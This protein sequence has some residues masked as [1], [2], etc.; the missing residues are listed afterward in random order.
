MVV[1]HIVSFHLDVHIHVWF[2]SLLE[3]YLISFVKLQNK[4]HYEDYFSGMGLLITTNVYRQELEY[5]NLLWSYYW[6]VHQRSCNND[7]GIVLQIVLYMLLV[8]MLL[9]YYSVWS[10]GWSLQL[11]SDHYL[12]REPIILH[13]LFFLFLRRWLLAVI[14]VSGCESVNFLRARFVYN[15]ISFF[16]PIFLHLNII[17]KL[18][19]ILRKLL[20]DMVFIVEMKCL[21]FSFYWDAI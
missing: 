11:D 14:I 18:S 20:R 10:L 3:L 12:G 17:F 6:E 7:E 8:C 19:G 2:C 21:S 16:Y 1:S 5:H 9:S 13:F 15:E 4:F